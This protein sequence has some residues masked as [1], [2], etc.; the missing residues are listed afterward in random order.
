MLV[1]GAPAQSSERHY[2]NVNVSPSPP[3][4]L[5][6]QAISTTLSLQFFTLYVCSLSGAIMSP[7]LWQAGQDNRQQ[8]RL[9]EGEAQQGC[10]PGVR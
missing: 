2:I 6:Q 8:N 7:R 5:I 1:A 4:T 9:T 10:K 3:H